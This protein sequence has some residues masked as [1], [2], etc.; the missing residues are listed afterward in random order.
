MPVFA[1]FYNN[2]VSLK[3]RMMV[4]GP[5]CGGWEMVY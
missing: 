3:S 2:S 1:L 5:E 4:Y